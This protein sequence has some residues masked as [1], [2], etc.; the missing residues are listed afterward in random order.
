MTAQRRHRARIVGFLVVA[1]GW[2]VLAIQPAAAQTP[3][4]I[5]A[6]PDAM[7][8]VFGKDTAGRV[9]SGAY[10]PVRL[11]AVLRSQK[12][13]PGFEC[14]AEPKI[15]LAEIIPYPIKAGVVSWIER[16]FV[17]CTPSTVRNF[18]LVLEN[19]Q[20]T[21]VELLP[22]TTNADPRLQR[23]AS[24][25]AGAAVANKVP[26]GCERRFVTETKLVSK[27]ER[28]VPWQERWHYDLCG[29]KA[30]VEMTFTPSE[31]SGTTWAA[32][33]IE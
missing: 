23:D 7:L 5:T 8:R 15:A 21:V 30:E 1:A 12:T 20:P 2:I 16:F 27:L 4:Y 25:G 22:G 24:L 18:L 11:Q 26:Q 17:A 19:Q 13:I 29:A 33:L 28:G 10:T 32:K 6:K 31:A 9:F 3:G 14:P